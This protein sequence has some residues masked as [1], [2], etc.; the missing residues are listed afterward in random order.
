M[1]LNLDAVMAICERH[2]LDVQWFDGDARKPSGALVRS[3]FEAPGTVLINKRLRNQEERLKYE[4]AFFIGH[5]ILHNGDGVISPHN[6]IQSG[7]AESSGSAAG[8]G[9][10]DV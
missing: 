5:K 9:A 1:P 10:Q 2:A 4:L 6:A 8:M 7:G 3:Q